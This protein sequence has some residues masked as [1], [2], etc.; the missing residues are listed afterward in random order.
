MSTIIGQSQRSIAELMQLTSYSEMSDD[1]VERI[2]NFKITLALEEQKATLIDEQTSKDTERILSEG[3]ELCRQNRDM[4]QYMCEQKA[5]P[6]SL[7]INKLEFH[8]MEFSNE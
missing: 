4:L 8:P 1:E 2:I 6:I 3:A 5:E 7:V